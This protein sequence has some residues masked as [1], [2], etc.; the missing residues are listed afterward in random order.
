[1]LDAIHRVRDLAYRIW[2]AEGCPAG[3]ETEHW[4]EAE[5]RVVEEG[6]AV[7]MTA[8][9]RAKKTARKA[10]T[11]APRVSRSKKQA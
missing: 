9:G 3:R 10:E 11:A 5:R 8:K 4:L 1:M 7:T 2:E 6:R